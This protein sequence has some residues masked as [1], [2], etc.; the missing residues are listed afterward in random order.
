M[1]YEFGALQQLHKMQQ[2]SFVLRLD[3]DVTLVGPLV[4]FFIKEQPFFIK[5]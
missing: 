5:I 4:T 2:N 1:F 3:E